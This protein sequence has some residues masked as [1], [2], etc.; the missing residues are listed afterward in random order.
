[1]FNNF[2]VALEVLLR[3]NLYND[4]SYMVC[5]NTVCVCVYVC[6]CV[7]VVRVCIGVCVCVCVCVCVYVCMYVL[8][9]CC[10]TSSTLIVMIY[11]S[12]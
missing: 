1:M 4:D 10:A 3:Y 9:M 12:F 6:V 5:L 7:R 8:C 11:S 2:C